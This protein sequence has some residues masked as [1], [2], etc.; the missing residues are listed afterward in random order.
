MPEE[1]LLD[2]LDK[3]DKDNLEAEYEKQSRV[4]NIILSSVPSPPQD[5]VIA[6]KIN[7]GATS[8]S[9]SPLTFNGT[10]HV[11]SLSSSPQGGIRLPP[12]TTPTHFHTYSA[13]PPGLSN[14]HVPFPSRDR[15]SS[16]NFP[17]S[18]GTPSLDPATTH[19]TQRPFARRP[20][21]DFGLA[22]QPHNTL[23]AGS[24]GYYCGFDSLEKANAGTSPA[25]NNVLMA[26]TQGGLDVY[27]LLRQRSDIIGRLEG[28]RGA[29]IDAK[30]LPWLE[31]YDP[32]AALRPLVMCVLHGPIAKPQHNLGDQN[33]PLDPSTDASIYQT[34]VEVYSLATAE[35][36]CTLYES[37]TTSVS[38]QAP[39]A[40]I[41]NLRTAAEG[42][43]I[44]VTSGI[45]GEVFVFSPYTHSVADNLPPFRCIAKFWTTTSTITPSLAPH[46][47]DAPWAHGEDNSD[48]KTPI[49]TLSPR[50]LA[51]KPPLLSSSQVS[52]QGSPLLSTNHPDP[53][54]VSAHVSP[55]PPAI[56]CGVD[57][58]FSNTL[59]DRVTKQ[60]TQEI[61]KGAQWVGEQGKQVW[62]A[63][64]GRSSPAQNEAMPEGLQRT[65]QFDTALFPPTHA[66]SESNPTP[67]EPSSISVIDLHRLLDFEENPVKGALTPLATFSLP[68]GCSFMSF[69]PGGLSILTTNQTG[70]A[71]TIWDLTRIT[72]GRLPSRYTPALASGMPYVCMAARFARQTP[73]VVTEVA[74]SA[75]GNRVALLTQ[76]GTVHLHEVPS[77]AFRPLPV[78]GG[79]LPTVHTGIASPGSSPQGD[80]PTNGFVSN[81][82]AR[83]QTLPGMT[84]RPTVSNASAF[85]RHTGRRALKQGVNI[86]T[87]TALKIRHHE[88]TKI[89][90]QPKHHALG[91]G[92]LQWLSGRENGLIATVFD[93]KVRLHTVKSNHYVQGN[94]TALYLT[95]GRRP[96]GESSLHSINGDALSPAS[97][98]TTCARAGPHGFWALNKAS[99]VKRPSTGRA[100]QFSASAIQD[101]DTNPTYLPFHRFP[102]V[103]LFTF[104]EPDAPMAVRKQSSSSA[105]RGMG[106]EEAWVFGLPLSP[107]AKITCQQHK[108][109]ADY[110]H[111][112]TIG[113]MQ[114]LLED[115]PE[116]SFRDRDEVGVFEM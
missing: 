51:I 15:K 47:P 106:T 59:F 1:S 44:T 42:C 25:A 60:A 91:P 19:I 110:I 98:S 78:S 113:D 10:Q 52:L 62:N 23:T 99:I 83:F 7:H 43:F 12:N 89:R 84:L 20:D 115:M 17:S 74:W 88:E 85:A 22:N 16:I 114:N 28:L 75:H 14:N 87:D 39:P 37:P 94:R 103:N 5:G 69:A 2:H 56:N 13:S 65:S 80:A 26:G 30:I 40:P 97:R 38:R 112:T 81:V 33:G 72:N 71:S 63:Y 105:S 21:M 9:L 66:Q 18:R 57:A 101:K 4:S 61:R 29:V 48:C 100:K 92:C 86:A 68:D 95:A 77:S 27:R 54:G 53:P 34:T 58:P 73:S 8:P 31:R 11:P 108:A 35:S 41:G 76:K 6:A 3:V 111:N 79:T 67:V 102:Q 109:E 45:S 70:D 107:A 116:E 55:P 82:R 36:V 96:V 90:M 104:A 93:G 32:F 64:W 46:A 50:W 49:C 24:K